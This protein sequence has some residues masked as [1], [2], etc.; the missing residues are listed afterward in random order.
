MP[1]RGFDRVAAPGL[2]D[3]VTGN[4]LDVA[5]IEKAMAGVHTLV[6]LAATPDD[7]DFVTELL[8]NNVL[9][10]YHVMEAARA[11]GVKRFIL[12]STAQVVW[13]QRQT[14][15]WPIETNTQPTPRG[16]YAATKVFLEA[17]GRVFAN[18]HGLE[19]LAIRL[20]WCPRTREQVEEIH[21]IDWAPDG[22][23]SPNDA[24]RFLALAVVAP[25]WQGFQIVY[26]SSKPI[27]KTYMDLE[28]ARKLIGYEPTEQWPQG[29]DIVLGEKK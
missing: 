15:P 14:G 29:V 2:D 1:V 24:G 9:G 8:P 25:P 20:G 4:L 17:V 28:P 5:S 10:V 18:T 7:A 23:L 21:T 13:H 26:A 11:A 27:T 22:Y 19:V 6:H 16:W 12:A 3:F